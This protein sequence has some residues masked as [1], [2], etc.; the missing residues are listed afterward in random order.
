MVDEL[1]TYGITAQVRSGVPTFALDGGMSAEY[2]VQEALASLVAGVSHTW[3]VQG[4]GLGPNPVRCTPHF[5][6]RSVEATVAAYDSLGADRQL[7][8]VVLGTGVAS[9]SHI[10]HAMGAPFLPT[11]F[12]ASGHSIADIQSGLDGAGTAGLEA[13]ATLAYDDSMPATA[14][15][16]LKLLA[17][18]P[19]YRDFLR[20]HR[21][22]TVV[23]LGT[24]GTSPH[25]ARRPVRPGLTGRIEPGQV[26]VTYPDGGSS[27]DAEWLARV[28][29]NLADTELE[30]N[31]F[32]IADWESG[33][34][35]EQ[36]AGL[37]AGLEGAVATTRLLSASDYQTAYDIASV[38]H[39]ALLRKNH[40]PIRQVALDPYL[41]THTTAETLSG[42]LPLLY[43]Q[44]DP[45]GAT[46]ARLQRVAR[47]AGLDQQVLTRLPVII[48]GTRNVGGPAHVHHLAEELQTAGFGDVA[49]TDTAQDELFDPPADVPCQRA[50]SLLADATGSLDVTAWA[51]SLQRLT[52]AELGHAVSVLPGVSFGPYD[53]PPTS[54]LTH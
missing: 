32:A 47:L 12:L 41:V 33:L 54:S 15:A 35:E 52:T 29:D 31:S 9:A 4:P 18:P 19:A 50:L 22:R 10:A 30:P 37:V 26:L 43:W 46:L 7:D 23:L 25:Q 1:L 40:I 28:I 5:L 44:L 42:S 16:W 36:L 45:V 11:H 21:V 14:V 39:A 48:N 2:A 17:L 27:Y 51:H 3:Q 49:A 13:Y 20:R 6:D 34:S 38:V 8:V 53:S 24:R